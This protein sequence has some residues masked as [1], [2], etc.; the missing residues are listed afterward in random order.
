M[1]R[2]G[3]REI[4]L[5]GLA[6]VHA[7]LVG[8]GSEA[9]Q[10]RVGVESGGKHRK[11]RSCGKLLQI[12]DDRCKSRSIRPPTRCQ[13]LTG[14]GEIACRLLDLDARGRHGVL[15]AGNFNRIRRACFHAPLD[16]RHEI[17]HQLGG[18]LRE[19]LSSLRGQGLD[20][21][22][23]RRHQYVETFPFVIE[24]RQVTTMSRH[25]HPGGAFAS[26]L[27]ELADLQGGFR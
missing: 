6:L 17:F 24:T 13:A 11:G 19:S 10:G 27:D 8:L 2:A 25:P 18:F 4:L 16:G 26:K 23:R 5:V 22:P 12:T 3:L 14:R 20:K 7:A 9:G 21:S 1:G 15:R